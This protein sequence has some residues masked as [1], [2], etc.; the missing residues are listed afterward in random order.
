[1]KKFHIFLLAT[2]L[3][4]ALDSCKKEN[5]QFSTIAISDYQPL[6]TGKY[7][8]YRLDS[9]V[10]LSFGTRDTTISYEAKFE[11]DSMITDN[12]NRPAYR[13]FRYLRKESTDPW[14]PSGTYM[15]I[16]TGNSLEFVENN[17]R[18]IKLL[19][20]VRDGVTWKGNSFIDTYSINSELKYMNDWDYTYASVEQPAT[21]GSYNLD[22][23]ITIQQRDEVIGDPDFL[24]SYTEINF[25]EEKYAKGI[26]LVYKK[27][28]HAEFQGDPAPGYFADGSYGI[29]LTMIDHN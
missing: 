14:T 7:V 13:I 22:K 15:A 27:F 8:T 3:C 28:F 9:L 29:T 11:V 2:I 10:Y 6:Q 16:N 21:V 19:A 1:M 25:S 24:S 20:P 5:D 4:A 26:G 18:F 17:L 23:T 12:L